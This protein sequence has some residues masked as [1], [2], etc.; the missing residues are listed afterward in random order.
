MSLEKGMGAWGE[1][2]R[3]SLL[4]EKAKRWWIRLVRNAWRV[5]GGRGV[6]Q[7]GRGRIEEEEEEG[8][9]LLLI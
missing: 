2:E 5:E 1:E 3:G 4:H 7:P 9:L 8:G 6:G